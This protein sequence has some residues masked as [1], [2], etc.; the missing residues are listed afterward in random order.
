VHN[1]SPIPDEGWI[2]IRDQ[3]YEG[4]VE[5]ERRHYEISG[6]ALPANDHPRMKEWDQA[7]T[8]IASH[9]GRLYECPRCGRLMWAKPKEKV[10]KVFSP[11]GMP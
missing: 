10:F 11:E 8:A 5:A 9:S 1:L 6:H 2:T 7:T 3:D 4:V